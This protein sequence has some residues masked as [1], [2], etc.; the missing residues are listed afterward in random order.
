MLGGLHLYLRFISV[1]IQSQI[2]YRASFALLTLGHFAATAVEFLA[3]LVL[4]DRFSA[5]GP[6]TLPE[7]AFLY[8]LVNIAFAI[9]D[10]AAFGFDKFGDM[11]KSGDFDRLLLR[12]RSTALQLAGQELTLRRVGRMAQG[13]AVLLWASAALDFGWTPD[14][15]ALLRGAIAGGAALFVGLVVLQATTAF[16]TTESLEIFNA[17][18]YGGVQASHFPLA[19]Y[20]PWIQNFF[21]YVVPPATVSYLPSL[22]IIGRPDPLGST[23]AVQYLSPIVGVVFLVISLQVWKLGVRHYQSTGS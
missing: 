3:I 4:F 18:T 15:V 14:K 22:A 21:M 13:L 12:P 16:W 8:G 19:I 10:A 20:R 1:S 7:V 5:L 6:W 2:Q 11:V 9:A 23:L 17:L